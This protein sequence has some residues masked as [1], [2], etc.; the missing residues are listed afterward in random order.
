MTG[1][2]EA[3]QGLFFEERWKFNFKSPEHLSELLPLTEVEIETKNSYLISQYLDNTPV[4]E[5]SY[6]FVPNGQHSMILCNI[7]GKCS[8]KWQYSKRDCF[9]HRFLIMYMDIT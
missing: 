4:G 3:L 5:V 1:G 7:F 6:N 2:T 9:C 8:Q